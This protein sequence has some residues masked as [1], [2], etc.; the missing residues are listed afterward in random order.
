MEDKG[1]K[2]PEIWLSPQRA[3]QKVN[4][5]GSWLLAVT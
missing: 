4:L 2:S 3:Q 1:G 5:R